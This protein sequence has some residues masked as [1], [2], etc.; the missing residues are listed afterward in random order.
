MIEAGEVH[1]LGSLQF[2]SELF[3]VGN[4]S[5]RDLFALIYQV[6]LIHEKQ[7]VQHRSCD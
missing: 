1:G 2:G 6:L 7:V 3:G 4:L 5:I